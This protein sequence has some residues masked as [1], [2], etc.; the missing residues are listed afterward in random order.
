MQTILADNYFT[1][2][3]SESVVY[4]FDDLQGRQIKPLPEWFSPMESSDEKVAVM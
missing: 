3:D 4:S 2:S 1:E